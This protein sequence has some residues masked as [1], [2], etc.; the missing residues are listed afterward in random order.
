MEF[1]LDVC[2]HL[3]WYDPRLA[4]YNLLMDMMANSAT[5]VHQKLWTPDLRIDGDGGSAADLIPRS[6][7]IWVIREDGP[8]PDD[9]S[10][11]RED[12]LFSG[13]SN[14]LYL[15]VEYTASLS[16]MFD[17]ANYPFDLQICKVVIR[18]HTVT[19]ADAV[20]KEGPESVRYLGIRCLLEYE[21]GHLSLDIDRLG[22]YS[23][24]TVTI[25][26]KNLYRYYI[27]NTYIPTT[28]L[29]CITYLTFFFRVDDFSDR[30]MVSLT[31]L[32][33]LA[34]LF[35]QTSA[36][37]PK[38]SYLKLIDIWFVFVI[39]FDFVMVVLLVIINYVREDEP[40]PFA[41]IK[42]SPTEKNFINSQKAKN[43]PSMRH[44]CSWCR[45][46]KHEVLNKI[47]RTLLPIIGLS[48]IS[49]YMVMCS[50]GLKEL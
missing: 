20:L 29:V 50:T 39:C 13:A 45:G 49:I 35:S 33:V 8:L 5:H 46:P 36:S 12:E 9:T 30:I 25:P 16:C 1:T 48:F 18:F 27:T 37:I 17:L 26:F 4:Y 28:L 10:R 19:S 15:R 47:S 24:A 23:I 3:K 21:V 34:A 41:P 7:H 31:A 2:M 43:A 32:L 6:R 22:N 42:V 44:P 40:K 38:T 14:P 11:A